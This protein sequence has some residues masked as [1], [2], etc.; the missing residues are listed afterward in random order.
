MTKLY[1]KY[2]EPDSKLVVDTFLEDREKL[3]ARFRDRAEDVHCGRN[4]EVFLMRGYVVKIPL[5]HCGIADNDWEGSVSNC[6]DYPQSDW[7]VQYARTRMVYV[8]D[9][10][11][12]FMERVEYVTGKEI[13]QRL[14]HEPNWTGCVDGGQ[15]GFNRSGRLVAFDYGIR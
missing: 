7:Q 1:K 6:E 12:V 5:N 2:R 11:V 8:N 15:V 10:P 4:R 3:C 9:I 13:V 14:G